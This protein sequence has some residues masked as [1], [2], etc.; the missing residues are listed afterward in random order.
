MCIE[1]IPFT[2]GT[3]NPGG[4]LPTFPKMGLSRVMGGHTAEHAL[5]IIIPPLF[6]DATVVNPDVVKYVLRLLSITGMESCCLLHI[7]SARSI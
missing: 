1:I 4:L 7:R 2:S 6:T 3:F 5:L